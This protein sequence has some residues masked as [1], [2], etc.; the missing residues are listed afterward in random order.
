[1]PILPGNNDSPLKLHG[2]YFTLKLGSDLQIFPNF[3]RGAKNCAFLKRM[4][5]LLHSLISG[6][7]CFILQIPMLYLGFFTL[8]VHI[9]TLGCASGNNVNVS[10][11]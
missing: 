1:M 7:N 11:K 2:H 10:G 6:A 5:I 4:P 8:N 3:Q 9:I